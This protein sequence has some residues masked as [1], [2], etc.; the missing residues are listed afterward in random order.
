MIR[1]GLRRQRGIAGGTASGTASGFTLLE[2]LVVLVLVA[3]VVGLVFEGLGRVADLRFRLARHLD[4]ALDGAIVGS[5]FRSSV[6]AMLPAQ[7]GAPDAFKGGPAEMS[8]LTL[9][10]LDQPTGAAV[11][12]A[13]RLTPEQSS[14][15]IRLSYRGADGRWREIAAWPVSGGSGARFLYAGPDGEWRDE[16]P[17]PLGAGR[18]PLGRVVEMRQPQLPRFV[19]LEGGNGPEAWSTAAAVAGTTMAPLGVTDILKTLR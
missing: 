7:E 18:T 5:W 9:Q 16:W 11:A 8:G 14:G 6:T 3:L 13:W 4:G 19:R 10:P 15:L 17:P 2:M 12:F 1:D